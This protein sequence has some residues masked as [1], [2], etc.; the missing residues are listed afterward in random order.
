[1]RIENIVSLFPHGFDAYC[2]PYDSAKLIWLEHRLP[3]SKSINDFDNRIVEFYRALQNLDRFDRLKHAIETIVS[4]PKDAK[5][6][7]RRLSAR[8]RKAI[9]SVSSV[10]ASYVQF[11]RWIGNARKSEFDRF[12]RLLSLVQ[13]DSLDPVRFVRYWDTEKTLFFVAPPR[14]GH[15]FA[16]LEHALAMTDALLECKGAVVFRVDHEAARKKLSDAG[17]FNVDGLW[18]NPVAHRSVSNDVYLFPSL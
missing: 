14:S 18:L 13:I 9:R 15:K 7:L 4:N 17:W 1:M 2:E 12:E 11:T 8:D 16:T 10:I 6:V 3:E 5:N